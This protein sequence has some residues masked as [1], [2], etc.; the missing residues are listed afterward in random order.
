MS[1]AWKKEIEAA[2]AG[3]ALPRETSGQIAPALARGEVETFRDRVT[4]FTENGPRDRIEQSPFGAAVRVRSALAGIE[5]KSRNR[6]DPLIFTERQHH[7]AGEYEALYLRVN[8]GRVKCSNLQGSGGGGARGVADQVIH[9][10][11]RLRVMDSRIG[12]RPVML[13]R[14]A[15]AQAGRRTLHTDELMFDALIRH[16]PLRTTLEARGWPNQSRHLKTLQSALMVLLDTIY[17]L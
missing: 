5:A 11:Q 9:D 4:Y 1:R 13:A 2:L 6:K 12:H 8:G 10:I 7:A 17:G 3:A 16:A 15:A 14:G